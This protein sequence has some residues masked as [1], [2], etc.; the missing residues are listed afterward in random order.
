MCTV[1]DH[2]EWSPNPKKREA[3]MMSTT[4]I[5]SRG[6]TP[7]MCIMTLS[8]ITLQGGYILGSPDTIL[9]ILALVGLAVLVFQ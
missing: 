3:G 6:P 7:Q 8:L 2:L 5:G 4:S 1:P 9:V